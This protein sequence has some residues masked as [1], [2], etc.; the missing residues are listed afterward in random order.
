MDAE[1]RF[2]MHIF[3]NQQV[4]IPPL[5]V[6]VLGHYDERALQY[7]LARVQ[8][9]LNVRLAASLAMCTGLTRRQVP[10]TNLLLAASNRSS[11]N[12][13]SVRYRVMAYAIASWFVIV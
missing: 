6:I 4:I 7:P 11:L 12:G 9:A 2:C 13:G 10:S 8:F 1:R 5:S 3:P